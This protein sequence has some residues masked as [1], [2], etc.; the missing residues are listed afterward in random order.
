M[1]QNRSSGWIEPLITADQIAVKKRGST[2]EKVQIPMAKTSK[3]Q[4][5]IGFDEPD[6]AR[7][8]SVQVNAPAAPEESSLALQASKETGPLGDLAGKSVYIVDSHSLIYQVFHAM[9]EMTGPSGQ[10]VGA[11]QGFMRDLVDLIEN[12]KAD[13]LICAFDH[14]SENFRHEI[15]AQYKQGRSEM[16][17]NLGLQIPVIHRVLEGMNIP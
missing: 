6:P 3:Q 8:P 7:K 16:P 15:Y 14:S 4:T 10:P 2:P 13:F 12:R 11:V 1:N 5:L 9:P 17:A